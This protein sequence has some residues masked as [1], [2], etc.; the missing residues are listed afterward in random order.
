MGI[1]TMGNG[2]ED[3]REWGQWEMRNGDLTMEKERMVYGVN[4]MLIP[5][6][7]I[8]YYHD[9]SFSVSSLLYNLFCLLIKYILRC[10]EKEYE[11]QR[12]I[13]Y[14]KNNTFT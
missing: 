1:G 7:S 9:I 5:Y 6:K 12:N 10:D 14:V 13:Y 3:G 11:D 4:W 2:D 8:K